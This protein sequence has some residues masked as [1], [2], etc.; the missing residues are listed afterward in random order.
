MNRLFKHPFLILIGILSV[1]V[2]FSMQ[3]PQIEFDNEIKNFVPEDNPVRLDDD[4]AERQFGSEM[5][6]VIGLET[7]TGTVFDAWS[8]S[9]IKRLTAALI[10]SPVVEEANSITSIDTVM[11]T[12]DGM[13]VETVLPENFDGS[14]EAVRD[15]KGRLMSWNKLL[16][17]YVS[18]DFSKTQIVLT[19]NEEIQDDKAADYNLIRSIIADAKLTHLSAYIAGQPAVSALLTTNMKK[20]LALLTPIVLLV[21][22]VVL[23]FAFRR[24]NG[25]TLPLLTVIL[26]TIWTVGMMA[27]LHIPLSMISTI[28]PVLL[29]AI[30]SAYG[31]HFIT[32]YY[33]MARD[34]GK[35]K[36]KE[37]HRSVIAATIKHTGPSIILAGLTTVAGFGALAASQIKPMRYFGIFSGLGVLNALVIS[38]L[39]IPALLLIV[40]PSGKRGT[41]TEDRTNDT[42]GDGLIRT[43]LNV[44]AHRKTVI[45][46]AALVAITAAVGGAGI[47]IDNDLVKYFKKDTEIARSDKFL[48]SNFNGIHTMAVVVEGPEKGALLEPDTLQTILG[49]K[50]Y[51]MERHPEIGDVYSFADLVMRMNKVMHW[52]D[53]APGSAKAAAATKQEAA[54]EQEPAAAVENG[55]WDFAEFSDA[56]PAVTPMANQN[57]DPTIQDAT[58]RMPFQELLN[59]VYLDRKRNDFSVETLVRDINAYTNY[60]GEAYNEIPLDPAKYGFIDKEQ[61][62]SLIAQYLLLYTGST[63]SLINDALEPSAANIKVQLKD[64]SSIIAQQVKRTI[65]EYC[66]TALPE[67]FTYT[68]SGS[69]VLGAEVTRLVTQA[70]FMSILLSLSIV[71]LILLVY[72]RSVAAGIIGIIPLSLAILINFGVMGFFKIRLDIS[73]AMIASI[74]IGI[75]IDYTIHFISTYRHERQ[76]SADL[77]TVCRKT[78]AVTGKA[79]IFNAVSVGLGFAVLMFSQFNPLVFL[80]AL[81]MLTMA[82]SSLSAITVLPVLL[83]IIQPSFLTPEKKLQETELILN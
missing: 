30:G 40:P 5:K 33:D 45:F 4:A 34:P 63:D 60:Q 69:A 78:I 73:T 57:Q 25:V 38:L 19:I 83:N 81:I 59:T 32:H 3:L 27:K 64:S 54:P 77:D 26:S 50:S 56:V 67:G 11:G 41:H 31:I 13:A 79:I 20:D 65:A 82:T 68:I 49:M 66:D 35:L 61:L 22:T 12:A 15:F 39:F 80:G 36:D 46:I 37:Y 62:S 6:M 71:F 18:S 1:S 17:G 74:A 53:P 7:M 8:L 29:I 9:E 14:P 44:I 47:I 21:V 58:P 70:Q 55:G 24:P 43:Y 52:N 72:F 16:N 48:N 10:K 76:R 51:L 2:Y 28:I 23:A 75:G 42:V